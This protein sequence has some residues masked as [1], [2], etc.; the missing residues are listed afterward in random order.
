MRI[1]RRILPGTTFDS[2]GSKAVIHANQDSANARGTS[3][4][5]LQ[6]IR[7]AATMVASGTASFM[8]S[9]Q[10]NTVSGTSSGIVCGDSNVNSGLNSLIGC[11]QLNL[12]SAT[13]GGCFIGS[14]AFNQIT[15]SGLLNVIT[16]GFINTITSTAVG[17][18]I[19]TGNQNNIPS[20][21][22][23]GILTGQFNVTRGS[24]SCVVTGESNSAT[25]TSSVIVA[26]SANSI[27][28]DFSAILNG[29][30][31]ICGVGTSTILGGAGARTDTP[32]EVSWGAFRQSSTNGTAQASNY[33][34]VTNTTDATSTTMSTSGSTA[35]ASNQVVIPS[36][37]SLTMLIQIVAMQKRGDGSQSAEFTRKV[38]IQ[39]LNGTTA[40]VGSVQ[41]IGTDIGSNGGSPPAGWAVSI[42]ANNTD[43]VLAIAVTGAAA[44]NVRWFA[45]I[46]AAQVGYT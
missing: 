46:T 28:N 7:S 13:G 25:G 30:N 10:N 3:A 34:L 27:S 22:Y 42:T 32:F 16:T 29:A 21:S 24:Y 18:A 11:G 31:N 12:L 40:I 33:V 44:T 1:D 8:G 20:G 35:S 5:D 23:N 19:I 26:G 45:R 9:G 14:G 15:G 6:S 17:C 41:T 37:R 43:D 39:N 38:L 36:D 2:T 4:V